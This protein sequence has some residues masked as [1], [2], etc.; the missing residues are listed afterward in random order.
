[1]VLISPATAS[2]RRVLSTGLRSSLQF[3]LRPPSLA[4]RTRSLSTT[5]LRASESQQ[6]SRP[7]SSEGKTDKDSNDGFRS[8][9]NSTGWETAMGASFGV[10]LLGGAAMVYH[11]WYKRHVLKKMEAAFDPGYDPVLALAK[12]GDQ[13]AHVRIDPPR[14]EDEMIRSIVSGKEAGRYFL[15]MGSKGSGK[16]TS[17]IEA[18]AAIDADGCAF[19]DAHLDPTIVVDRFSESI[20]FSNNRDYLGNLLGLSDLSGMSY[21]QQ[22]E[23]ALHK[24]ERA[25]ITRKQK[26]GKPAI[27]VMNSA[28]LLPRDEEGTKL[29]HIF[30]QRAEKWASAGTATFVFTSADYWVYDVLRKASNRMDTLSFRDLTRRQSINV[31]RGC[32]KQYWGEKPSSQDPRVLQEVYEI[33]G[34]RLGLLNKVARR[35]DMLRAARQMVEDDMQWVLSKTGIIEDHDDDVMDEQKW[36]TCSWL[37]FCELS[38]KQK[39]LE[40]LLEECGG[41]LP[42]FVNADTVED[43]QYSSLAAQLHNDAGWYKAKASPVPGLTRFTT[44]ALRN[45]GDG[46]DKQSGKATTAGDNGNDDDDDDDDEEEEATAHRRLTESLLTDPSMD[47]EADIR[48]ADVP[49]PHLTWGEARQVM[50]R[51]DFIMELDHLNLIHIDRH[52]HIR[53]DSMP[54]LRAMRRVAQSEGYA[55]KL[56]SVMDRVSAIESLGRTR[57]L[58]WKEQGDGGRFLIKKD[59][60]GREVESWTLLGGDERL[61][62]DAGDGDD[63][64]DQ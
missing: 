6:Q 26:T 19:F 28:H 14:P 22:L 2:S 29:L 17:I 24:L 52:H 15:V 47:Q 56:E 60:K 58:L 11:S 33:C 8:F 9:F 62:R 61:G 10:L 37:L 18:M 40:D 25:L 35:K 34:G 41:R 59:G 20:N 43:P 1:M 44:A 53:A 38:K 4:L 13:L 57:E 23:R 48:G 5:Q 64:G 7:T 3:Q 12:S 39:E 32:R 55:D 42:A 27:I 45:D 49:N 36:S 30:Q 21:Y 50:T 54:L 31:L 51:P 63:D 46:D 16:A